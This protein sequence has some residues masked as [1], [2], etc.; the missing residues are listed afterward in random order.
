MLIFVLPGNRGPL[1]YE[2]ALLLIALALLL[3]RRQVPVAG[4]AVQG[5]R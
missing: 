1:F 2:P 4:T 3:T 5:A